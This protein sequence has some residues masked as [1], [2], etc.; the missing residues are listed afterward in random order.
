MFRLVVLFAIALACIVDTSDRSGNSGNSGNSGYRNVAPGGYAQ[1]SS[2]KSG[3]R[4][5]LAIDGNISGKLSDGSCALT[6]S[7]EE[8]WWSV[9]LRHSFLNLAVPVDHVLIYN[10]L[11]SRQKRIHGVQVG[12]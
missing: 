10:R 7:E 11:D 4:A 2:S 12:A 9:K 6:G 5:D 1:A 3:S 8:N